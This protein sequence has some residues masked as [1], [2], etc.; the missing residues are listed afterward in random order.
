M[1]ASIDLNTLISRATLDGVVTDAELR[2]VGRSPAAKTADPTALVSALDA[3][4]TKMTPTAFDRFSAAKQASSAPAGGGSLLDVLSGKVATNPTTPAW[5]KTFDFVAGT[6]AARAILIAQGQKPETIGPG[7]INRIVFSDADL[8]LLDTST[9]VL[10]KNA[11][12]GAHLRYPEGTP[13]AGHLVLLGGGAERNAD[14]ELADLKLAL[15]TLDWA[16]Y[17]PD[18]SEFNS[19][20]EILRSGII[21]DDL[22]TL[23]RSDKDPKSKDFVITSR[24]ATYTAEYMN[25]V[26]FRQG[27]D[28][29]GVFAVNEATQAAQLNTGAMSSAQKKAVTMASLILAYGGADSIKN[30]RFMDD[31]DKNLKA[32]WELLPKMF[33]TIHFDFVDVIESAGKSE[34]KHQGVAH[35]TAGGELA[36]ADGKKL[37]VEGLAAYKSADRYAF[38]SLVYGEQ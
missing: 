15:P 3:F 25:E 2:R 32:A 16:S 27:I 14:K 30:V 35:T 13:R 5:S 21:P 1:A 10:L 31:T 29:N 11:T 22:S 34:F 23:K 9:P 8:T 6:A 20:S 36:G 38:D 4:A 17:G 37:S 12:T 33:P 24:S 18:Y 28:I 7:L 26:L 19:L